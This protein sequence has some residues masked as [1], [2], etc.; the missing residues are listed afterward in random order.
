MQMVTVRQ[1][2]QT[3]VLSG[4]Q[5]GT[6]NNW[7]DQQ[8]H[9]GQ[10]VIVCLYCLNIA[11]LHAWVYVNLK[12]Q[13]LLVSGKWSRQIKL[14]LLCYTHLIFLQAGR[15]HSVFVLLLTK[16]CRILRLMSLM[17]PIISSSTNST[18]H[19]LTPPVSVTLPMTP[20]KIIRLDVWHDLVKLL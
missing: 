13:Q 20:R 10:V 17:L 11:K 16:S 8:K 14:I 1:S 4:S 9:H 19:Y 5:R 3:Q 2:L 6:E 12:K 18:G 7:H 15:G